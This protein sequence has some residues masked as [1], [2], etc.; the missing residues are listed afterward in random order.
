MFM[1]VPAM[2]LTDYNTKES[3]AITNSYKQ[4]SAQAFS[5]IIIS[6]SFIGCYME[7]KNYASRLANL[8]INACV[9]LTL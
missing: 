3:T 4:R 9:I 8:E 5:N 1:P 6:L 2:C 7:E